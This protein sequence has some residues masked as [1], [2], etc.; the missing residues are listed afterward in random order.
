[1]RLSELADPG[2]GATLGGADIEIRGLSAD[3][4]KIE[5]G[6]L[7]AALN[8]TKARGSD[9]IAE[10]MRRG[11][12]A[13]LAAPDAPVPAEALTLPRL[14]D[15]N[16]RRR[17][18]LMAARFYG[19]QPK[20]IA[21]VTG[22]N[23]KS[24]VAA[25]TRQI[26][27]LDGKPAASLGTL[28]LEA[29]GV[30]RDLG[31]TTPDPVALHAALAELARR[32]IDH[33]ALEASSHGL[34]QHR[35]DGVRIRAAAFTNITRDHLDYHPDAESYFTAKL[36]LFDA[37][38]AEG[39]TAVL[40][41]DV[42]EYAALVKLCRERR[43]RIVSYG[44]NGADIRLVASAPEGEGQTLEIEVSGERRR[45]ALRM[46]GAFQAMN[47]LA[48]LGLA[49][50]CG[51]P[52]EHALAAL[53]RLRPVRG[54]LEA[55]PG[56]PQGALV[57][58]DYAHTPDALETV[59][60][61]L[62]PYAKA[63]LLALFGCGG[64]RDRGK[65]PQMGAIAN[66]LA[67]RVFVTDDNPRSE[68]PAAIRREILAAC[69]GAR[70]IGDRAEAIRAAVAELAAGDVLLIAGKGHERGQIAGGRV[71]PFDDVEVARRALAELSGGRR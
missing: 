41:A 43:H 66:R 48:A 38:M 34:A 33:L 15:G 25:F 17:L 71:V 22:T 49:L 10:A 4:R 61:A 12:V 40:N 30:A 9:F 19:A 1:M 29:P 35:L 26:W 64:E 55:V 27:A 7:F 69:P 32:G 44:T 16:P 68:D 63:R 11:A 8:G 58:V 62:R 57:Y 23:G 31:H 36:R 42:P 50:A 5:P 20:T 70:E 67:D 6:F 45:L 3:S 56:H 65:R 51:T 53:P 37:V 60:A 39:G 46:P 21:A 14:T 24:S 13:L 59:L 28:G 54:R 2:H 47:L 18:A 52:L